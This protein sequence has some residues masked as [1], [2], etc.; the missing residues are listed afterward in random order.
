MHNNNI[1]NSNTWFG[2]K[3]HMASASNLATPGDPGVRLDIGQLITAMKNDCPLIKCA[4]YGSTPPPEDSFWRAY[5]ERKEVMLYTR[6]QRK[7]MG[8]E[9]GIDTRI[10]V[11]MVQDLN[12]LPT[13]V[14]ARI[15]GIQH[16]FPN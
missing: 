11:D 13:C 16:T 9:K 15:E 6:P 14:D 2:A 3:W 7:V 5:R 12:R 4:V 10:S 8:K 1:D